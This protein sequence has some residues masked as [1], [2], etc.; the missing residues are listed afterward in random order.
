MNTI[1][2]A[3]RDLR[4]VGRDGQ[5]REFPGPATVE[6]GQQSNCITASTPQGRYLRN[7]DSLL[8]LAVTEPEPRCGDAGPSEIRLACPDADPPAVTLRD[9]EVL[10][11]AWEEILGLLT[12][13][14]RRETWYVNIDCIEEAFFAQDT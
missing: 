11:Y 12:V 3:C 4:F 1:Q 5:S 6:L 9:E 8:Y 14:C 7:V 10:D 13:R 2:H